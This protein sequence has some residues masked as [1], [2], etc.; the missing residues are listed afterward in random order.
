[1]NHRSNHGVPGGNLS[2]VADA[3]HGGIFGPRLAAI[4]QAGRGHVR[5]AK[6]LLNLRNI[7]FMSKHVRVGRGPHRMH[8]DAVD[9]D[10]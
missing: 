8:T 3:K 5:M 7:R 9:L 2:S 4:V 10:A 6:P 1:M